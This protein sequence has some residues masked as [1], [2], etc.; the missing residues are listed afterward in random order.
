LLRIA[1]CY[2]PA[3]YKKFVKLNKILTK[4]TWETYCV[5]KVSN[6]SLRFKL[7]GKLIIMKEKIIQKSAE[8]HFK[9]GIRNV[10]MDQ[11]AQEL[12]ISKKTIYQY[13][14][15][16]TDLVKQTVD[17]IFDQI[18]TQIDQVC[19]MKLN[20]Y[21]ELLHIKNIVKDMLSK[22]DLSPHHQLK[23]YYPEIAKQLEE[24]KFKSVMECL[25]H[26][27]NK[28][29][30]SGYYKKDLDKEFIK[31]MYFSNTLNL[32]NPDLFPPEQFNRQKTLDM[33]L[34]M[35]LQGISTKKG[36]KKLKEMNL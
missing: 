33:F 12:G 15:N 11:I 3:F 19:L 7:T 10:T 36:R 28:G 21:E 26:N 22:S 23:K 29:I 6:V 30:K 27:L 31:R 18:Q 8:L 20:P 24:R 34:N 4:N 13:F 2:C 14:E 5:L 32:M 17:S 25:E 9:Y 35:F 16:K 1:K